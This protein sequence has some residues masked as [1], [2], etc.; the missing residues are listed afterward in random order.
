MADPGPGL[1][2]RLADDRPAGD[3]GWADH[4]IDDLDMTG[5]GDE[6][7]RR[8]LAFRVRLRDFL[9]WSEREAGAAGLTPALHQL[10]LVVRGES[11]PTISDVAEKLHIRHNS[12][13][14]LVHRAD[15]AGLLERESD[16]IDSRLVRLSLTA[17]GEQRLESL[18]LRHLPR[19]AA[20][21]AGLE[22][23][24]RLPA[25]ERRLRQGATPAHR[26]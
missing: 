19:I 9:R 1:R 25:S 7:Y 5:L 2:G 6:D 8:L 18:T 26:R 4:A 14:E 20:L 3:D 16:P 10:L 21:A 23:V 17:L 13:V 24:V 22:E 15:T 11:L 12:V